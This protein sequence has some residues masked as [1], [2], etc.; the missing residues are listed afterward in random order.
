[1]LSIIDLGYFLV[2][3]TLCYELNFPRTPRIRKTFLLR[4]TIESVRFFGIQTEFF[5]VMSFKGVP[6]K[7]FSSSDAAMACAY[8]AEFWRT[9]SSNK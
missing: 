9:L 7:H 3:P 8:S 6:G 1:M 4:R 2:T 5:S